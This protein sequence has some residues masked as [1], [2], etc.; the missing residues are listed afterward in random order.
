MA[1]RPHARQSAKT[2]AKINYINDVAMSY[3]ERMFPVGTCACEGDLIVYLAS[4]I[5]NAYNVYCTKC[6]SISDTRFPKEDD[7]Y[8]WDKVKVTATVMEGRREFG[9]DSPDPGVSPKSALVNV[10]H[11]PK[12]IR[13]EPNDMEL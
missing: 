7:T 9:F 6:G 11:P 8:Y 2:N 5:E 12:E 10:G 3:M 4:D 1:D 13:N